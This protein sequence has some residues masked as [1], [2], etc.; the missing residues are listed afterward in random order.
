MEK[1]NF[2]V[3]KLKVLFLIVFVI[4]SSTV[5]AEE[6]KYINRKNAKLENIMRAIERKFDIDFSYSNASLEG[7][8]YSI[9]GKY[10]LAEL[11]Q[12]LNQE[13]LLVFEK[14]RDRKYIVYRKA[15]KEA[16]K[17][18]E[19]IFSYSDQE[20]M[21][22][23]VTLS[24]VVI[25]AY[26]TKGI[27][28]KV[29]GANSLDPKKI[30]G[31]PGHTEPDVLKMI[32]MLPGITSS[33]ETASNIQVRG[34]S[35][36][37]NLI[38]YDG[39]KMYHTGHFFGMFSAF[40]PYIVDKIDVYRSATES[41]FGDRVSSIIDIKTSNK[42]PV[43]AHGSVGTNMTHADASLS[44]PI[45]K[46]K[47]SIMG[48]L[49]RSFNDLF[50][51]PTS[52]K[53]SNIVFQSTK[54]S[55]DTLKIKDD[56]E[57]QVNSS[58]YFDTNVKLLWKPTD[59]D[60]ISIGVL[61]LENQLDYKLILEEEKE[62]EEEEESDKN[63]ANTILMGEYETDFLKIKN[64]G[65]N[66]SWNKSWN[67]KWRHE[68]H[69][70]Y[71][72]YAA[73]YEFQKI[74]EKAIKA[75][76]KRFNAVKD[77]G[78]ST[79]ITYNLSEQGK[80]SLG[81]QFYNM[82]I[83]YLLSKKQKLESKYF[84]NSKE[85]LNSHTAYLNYWRRWD[86]FT[87]NAGV[88][89][90]YLSS[91][92]KFY[93]EPR[94][95][96]IWKLNK[97]VN[98]SL[99]AEV[100][101]QAASQFV[102]LETPLLL[103]NS[104]WTVADGK[105]HFVINSTQFTAGMFF[106]Q[107]NWQVDI[108]AYYKRLSHLS[109]YLRGMNNPNI[110]SGLFSEG[111]GKTVGVDF[112]IKRKLGNF[113]TWLSY[114]FSNTEHLFPKIQKERFSAFSDKTHILKWINMYKWNNLEISIGWNYSTGTPYTKA[115]NVIENKNTSQE[116]K[117]AYEK[118]NNSRLKAYHRLDAS[119]SYNFLLSKNNNTRA[120]VGFSLLNI[121]NQ[122]NEISKTYSIDEEKEKGTSHINLNNVAVEERTVLGLG[123][124]PNIM[125]RVFF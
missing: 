31:V 8:Y 3:H 75:D 57:K 62:E 61:F 10:T 21:D 60:N 106:H 117:I 82:K 105:K 123:L 45:I 74:E 51:T 50:E 111:E 47:L 48:S 25:S 88:R 53:Y 33:N 44:L 92:N 7:L 118:I 77:L 85:T 70:Y 86:D 11:I 76:V 103:E 23:M 20:T 73:N 41:K 35:P 112:L 99:S 114:T 120:K 66:A 110:N 90:N 67:D 79:E 95:N 22:K 12:K 119:I 32:Q 64:Y 113:D 15:D 58:Y 1:L 116:Y 43:K 107:N 2:Q 121:Y 91:I 124:T 52:N 17:V 38:L 40:N 46:N 83:E 98:L 34:G 56:Y 69:L 109:S 28:R 9:K 26:L 54:I 93:V 78:I 65:F 102:E 71:S 68:L 36:D 81:Y 49:R 14:V 89:N 4:A 100:K 24:E 104:V 115:I 87:I 29:N 5:K 97:R 30:R 42:V 59:K 6:E 84:D 101:N 19:H 27:D 16:A 125:F 39:I 122:K 63:N 96:L 18:E 108:E 37:Q 72:D 80:L 94:L 55:A 13:T